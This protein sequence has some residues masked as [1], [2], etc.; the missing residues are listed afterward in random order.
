M[1]EK[2]E[3]GGTPFLRPYEVEQGNTTIVVLEKPTDEQV[4]YEGKTQIKLHVATEITQIPTKEQYEQNLDEEPDFLE[5]RLKTNKRVW[6]VNKTT[7]NYLIDKLGTDES[8]WVGEK[9][10][11]EVQKQRKLKVIYAKGS[12]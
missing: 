7:R 2:Q 11:L 8:K 12:V 3:I 1:I 9:I 5:N 10:E 4:T 6:I